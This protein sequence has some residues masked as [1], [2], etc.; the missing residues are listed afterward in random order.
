MPS[1]D[2][3]R[4]AVTV[5]VALLTPTASGLSILLIQRSRPPFEGSWALPG[6]FVDEQEN[7]PLAAHRELREETGLYGVGLW[8][9]GNAGKPG[10]DPRGWTISLLY[11]GFVAPE[12]ARAQAADDAADA[13]WFLVNELPSLAFDHAE[14][15][16][17]LRL[18][19]RDD[20]WLLPTLRPLLP[21]E[22][23]ER[24]FAEIVWQIEPSI[25]SAAELLV[26]LRRR[27]CAEAAGADTFRLAATTS[28]RY[29]DAAVP[30]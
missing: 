22:F 16:E 30:A 18:Q 9:F 3:P 24:E 21:T 2:Y 13:R 29:T 17:R 23:S 8:E 6:G 5:D 25:E 15:I 20:L 4:P 10:R 19:V 27:G 12:G 11:Y 1:Y 26:S 28:P 14:L 7:P